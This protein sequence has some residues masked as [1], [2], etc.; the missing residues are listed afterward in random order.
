M[1][2][3]GNGKTMHLLSWSPGSGTWVE[4]EEIKESPGAR[5]VQYIVRGCQTTQVNIVN[6]SPPKYRLPLDFVQYIVIA[7]LTFP[8]AIC[9]GYKGILKQIG[10][11]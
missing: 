5:P 3:A 10:I 7:I 9:P 11:F 2:E 8:S 6:I 4:E 1:Q